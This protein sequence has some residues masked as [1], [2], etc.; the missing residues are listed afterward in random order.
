MA[1][2]LNNLMKQAQKMQSKML[3]AQEELEA[4]VAVGTAGGGVVT[5][6]VNGK[7][8]VTSVKIDPQVVDPDDVEMLED[9]VLAAV[10]KAME[11][12]Q[13]KASEK[14]GGITGGLN[15]PGLM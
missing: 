15:I 12:M 13:A 4:E 1:K 3:N 8:T 11:E 2:G 6:E 5:V 9:L 7:Q 10:N 14:F